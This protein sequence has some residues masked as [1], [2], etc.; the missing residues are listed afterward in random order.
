MRV[1][2][3]DM[4]TIRTVGVCQSGEEGERYIGISPLYYTYTYFRCVEAMNTQTF[5]MCYSI[6][7]YVYLT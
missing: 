1:N 7:M 4:I 3:T 2:T 6:H 5:S